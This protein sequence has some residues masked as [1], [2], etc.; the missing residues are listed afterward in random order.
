[1]FHSSFR[2]LFNYLYSWWCRVLAACKRWAQNRFGVR[3]LIQVQSNLN[4]WWR[5]H[6]GQQLLNNENRSLS[7]CVEKL[8]GNYLMQ[9][10]VTEVITPFER[11]SV[12]HQFA[13]A[14]VAADGLSICALFESLPLSAE[15]VDVAVLQHSLDYSTNPHQLLRDV[16][17]VLTPHGHVLIV[18]FNPLSCYGIFHILM[19]YTAPRAIFCH[20]SLRLRR[21]QDWL[22]LLN[23]ETL[24]VQ[25]GFARKPMRHQGIMSQL[26]WLNSLVA[27]L[28]LPLGGYYVI[29]AQKHMAP[30]TPVKPLWS[31][32]T[33]V[34]GFSS[35]SL[36]EQRIKSTRSGATNISVKPND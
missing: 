14:P 2:L 31:S 22:R 24:Q 27:W 7:T 5:S 13:L 16:A 23:F 6:A 36:A 25:H 17:R 26:K 34:P 21:V 20:H 4:H 8:H 12:Q 33:P 28:S 35:H 9:L 10:G 29:V 18:G 11:C 15:V 32:I 3:P 30:L 19:R 1:M